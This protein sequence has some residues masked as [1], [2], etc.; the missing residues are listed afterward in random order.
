[1]TFRRGLR[2]I[3]AVVLCSAL[4]VLGWVARDCYDLI[5]SGC[6]WMGLVIRQG[7]PSPPAPLPEGE[8]RITTT[9]RLESLCHANILGKAEPPDS[10]TSKLKPPAVPSTAPPTPGPARLV[11]VGDV[12]PLQDRNYLSNVKEFIAGADLA[13]CNLE[14]VLS[15]HGAKTPLKFK[16]GRVIRNE[17]F[18]QAA[19][20]HGNRLAAAGQ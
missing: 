10:G 3:G 16:N 12:L 15:T 4:V 11:F 18:F 13:V 19:P 5:E 14:C 7:Q 17:F 8:G 9:H 2:I 6:P 20:A 1:M